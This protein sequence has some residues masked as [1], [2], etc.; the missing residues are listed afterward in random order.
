ME[1]NFN[2]NPIMIPVV[3]DRQPIHQVL[4]TAILV[5]EASSHIILKT[6]RQV[7]LVQSVLNCY[8][9]LASRIRTR[10]V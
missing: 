6:V 2:T 10:Y 8:R 7:Y 5:A 4:N 3:G 9:A 1:I